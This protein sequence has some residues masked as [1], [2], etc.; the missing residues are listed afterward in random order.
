MIEC[1]TSIVQRRILPIIADRATKTPVLLLEGPRSVGKSTMLAQLAANA[2]VPVIDLD[3]DD[4]RR[5]A[6]TSPS[7]VAAAALPVM[8]DEYQRV[9]ALLDAIKARLNRETRPGMFIIAGSASYD[10]LPQGT[11]ALTGR[12]QRLPVLPL[13]QTEIDASGNRFI[14]QAFAGE[15]HHTG[16]LSASSR[17]DY[18][19]RVM[20][21]GMPLALAQPSDADRARWFEG[22]VRQSIERDAGD[23]RRIGRN[24]DLQDVLVR[25]VGQTG[26]VFNV[27]KVAQDVGPAW[28]TVAAYVELLE[29]LFLIQ[30]LPAWGVTVLPRGTEKPKIHVV[31]SGIGAHLL[32][33]S[34]AKMD[35]LD[36]ASLTEF[37]HLLESFVVQEVIRQTTWLNEP[38]RAGHWRTRDTVEVDLVLERYDGA[39]IAIEIKAGDTI[40]SNQLSPLIALRER[41]GASFTAGIVFYTGRAGYMVDDRIHVLPIDRLWA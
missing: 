1:M 29:S 33:L 37:G 3:Q 13:T 8:I 11:Q 20:R 25:A 2:D 19:T 7:G 24:T 36:P 9:P 21:G 23:L 17:A 26:S 22:H 35:R 32:R 34:P 27:S 18:V 39:V 14:A 4:Y 40:R 5:I 28:D 41:L 30:R 38:V 16:H 15:I 31:D 12:L 6:E 10:S